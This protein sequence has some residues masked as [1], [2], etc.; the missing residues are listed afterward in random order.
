LSETGE[1]ADFLT[2]V[3]LRRW[4][5]NLAASSIITGAV[6][7]CKLGLYCRLEKKTPKGIVE[8]CGSKEFRDRFTDFVREMEKKGGPDF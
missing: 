8:R 3:D 5:D 6:Y 2:N 7:L 1:Y 4:H